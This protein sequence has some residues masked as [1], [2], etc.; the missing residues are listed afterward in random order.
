MSWDNKTK[1]EAW[2]DKCVDKEFNQNI[3]KYNKN[4]SWRFGAAITVM[5]RL[6]KSFDKCNDPEKKKFIA[7][8]YKYGSHIFE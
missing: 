1:A 5:Q 4:G 3:D 2:F 8:A 6:E 7:D